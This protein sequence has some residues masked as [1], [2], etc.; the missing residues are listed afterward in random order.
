MFISAIA[1]DLAVGLSEQVSRNFLSL[2]LIERLELMSE[3]VGN[4]S[5]I[6]ISSMETAVILLY[7]QSEITLLESTKR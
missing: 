4:C 7:H 6:N 1:L 5:N 3:T 2:Q